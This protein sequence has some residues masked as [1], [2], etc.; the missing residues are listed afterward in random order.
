M[1]EAPPPKSSAGRGLMI[2]CGV[3]LLLVLLCGGFAFFAAK[4]G[5]DAFRTGFEK[6]AEEETHAQNW[7]PP[8]ADAPAE[9]FAPPAVAGYERTTVDENAAFPALGIELDGHHA[10]YEAGGQTVEVSAYRADEAQASAAFEEVRRRI[11]TGDRFRSKSVVTTTRRLRFDVAPPDLHGVLWS[12]KGWLIFARSATVADLDPFLKEYLAQ[13]AGDPQAVPADEATNE[14]VP[15]AEMP[16]EMP[17]GDGTDADPAT[18]PAEPPTP[19]APQP[20][21]GEPPA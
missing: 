5:F 21:E 20:S 14:P 16:E 19:E 15:P 2:G 3:V 8:A 12:A 18:E 13:I 7:T 17:E 9:A 6:L 1:S 10:V 11:D 4:R